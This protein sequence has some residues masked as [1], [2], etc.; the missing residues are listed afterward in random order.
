MVRVYIPAELARRIREASRN[1]CGYCL[2]PQYL[3]LGRLQIEHL[4]PRA[5]GGGTEESNLWLSCSL[6]NGHKSDR[7]TAIDPETG[8]IQSIFNPRVQSWAEH[9]RWADG[10]LRIVGLTPVGRATVEV[11]HL[12]DDPNALTVRSYWILAGW[13]PPAD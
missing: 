9:F 6:C 5:K 3:V 10:G 13:H 8:E 11:L 2:S 7:T 4:V 1:R 12:S